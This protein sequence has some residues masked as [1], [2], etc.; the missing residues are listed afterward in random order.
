VR[1]ERVE[2]LEDVARGV[3]GRLD[4]A[5]AGDTAVP[6]TRSGVPSAGH[7]AAVALI[8]HAALGGDIASTQHRGESHWFNRFVTERGF[9]DVDLTGDQ[10]GYAPVRVAAAGAL[11]PDTR[12]R[13]MTDARDET[14]ERAI[15]LAARA[16]LT[17]AV[18][19]LQAEISRR[20]IAARA[21][22]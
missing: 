3:R 20:L 5:F 1:Y 10:F 16:G 11:F 18:R 19:S 12:M 17:D 6:G 7:C 21:T 14:I 22:A 4:A 9:V 13:Q 15:T 2:A 8:V